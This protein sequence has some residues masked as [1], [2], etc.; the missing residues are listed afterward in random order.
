MCN[1]PSI[2]A[3]EEKI[4]SDFNEMWLKKRRIKHLILTNRKCTFIF[5]AIIGAFLALILHIIESISPLIFIESIWPASDKNV[6]VNHDLNYENSV[7]YDFAY[8]NWL[9]ETYKIKSCALNPDVLRYTNSTDFGKCGDNGKL[10]NFIRDSDHFDPRTEAK[11]L[12][13]KVSAGT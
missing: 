4:L 10:E 7:N 6:Q 12:F 2:H 8:E 5:G 11:F 3:Y 1:F 9:Q 13:D